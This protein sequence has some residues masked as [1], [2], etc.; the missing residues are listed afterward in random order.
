MKRK[1]IRIAVATLLGAAA[2]GAQ[3]A[4]NEGWYGGLDLGRSTQH[5]GG[6]QID[7]AL[8][9]QGLASSSSLDDHGT[10]WGLFAGY[11]FNPYFAVEGGYLN[12]G[13]FDYSSTV[14][15]PAADTVSGHLGVQGVDAAAVG[16]LPF[17]KQ[18]AAYGKAGLLY[19]KSTLDASSTGAVAVSDADHWSTSPLLGAGINYDLTRNVALRGE[20]DR[21][22]KV[23]DTTTG[24]GDIDAFTARVVYRF[25]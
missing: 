23:G 14:S 17:G 20:Y 8:G 6:G 10:A 5:L 1:A 25:Q 12:L 4:G 9:Q 11:Q 18:W 7:G 21:Y 15:S 19:A 13:K 2:A 22:F 16:L 3:A 24:K